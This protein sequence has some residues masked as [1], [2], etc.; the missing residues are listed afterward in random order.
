MLHVFH[1]VSPMNRGDRLNLDGMDGNQSYESSGSSHWCLRR[2]ISTKGMFFGNEL[3]ILLY[4][5]VRLLW[6]CVAPCNRDKVGFLSVT[7]GLKR[8]IRPISRDRGEKGGLIVR[9]S[10][11]KRKASSCSKPWGG[12]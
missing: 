11:R 9:L 10:E 6:F 12:G 4:L 7:L 2:R 8:F 3:I 1:S 5:L